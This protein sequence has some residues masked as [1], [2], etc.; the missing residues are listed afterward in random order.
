MP[1]RARGAGRGRGRDATGAARAAAAV[2]QQPPGA[3]P[4]PGA[5][6]EGS[7]GFGH[8]VP[9][10]VGPRGRGCRPGAGEHTAEAA[11]EW[12]GGEGGMWLRSLWQTPGP[13]CVA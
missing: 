3:S 6:E 9:A 1:C 2:G 5:R 7:G 4:W 12:S 8:K 10:R 13:F 11:G